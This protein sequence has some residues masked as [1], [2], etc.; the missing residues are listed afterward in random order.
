[1][2]E[3]STE[4]SAGNAKSSWLKVVAKL[5]KNFVKHNGQKIL[6]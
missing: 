6:K 3:N 1:M 5:C 2:A 4:K